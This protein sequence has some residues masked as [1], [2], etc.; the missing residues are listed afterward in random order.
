MGSYD[1]MLAAIYQQVG[2][3]DEAIALLRKMMKSRRVDQSTIQRRIAFSLFKMHHYDEAEEALKKLLERNPHDRTA[4]RWLKGLEDA[5]RVGSY[6][7]AEEIINLGGLAEEGIELS[8]LAQ[9]AINNCTFEGVEPKKLQSGKITIKEAEHLEDLAKQLGTKR[10][11]DR[12]AFFLS[13]AAIMQ[14]YSEDP[15]S[16]RIYGFLRRYFNSMADASWSDKKPADVVRSYYIESLALAVGFDLDE[17]WRS[18]LRYLATFAPGLLEDVQ[19][20][21]P[22]TRHITMAD[23]SRALRETLLIVGSEV[24]STILLNGLLAVGSQSSFVKESVSKAITSGDSI[25]SL[26]GRLLGTSKQV[27]PP[28]LRKEWQDQCRD[29]AR[30][31]QKLLAVCRTLV[32]YE[33]TA[34][35]MEDLGEQLG[36]MIS[37]DISELD[38]S[39]IGELQDI[40]ECSYDYCRGSD[41]EEKEQQYW[42]VTTR[43]ERLLDSVQGNPTQFSYEG[44]LP[45]SEQVRAVIEEEYAQLVRTSGA[46][47]TLRLLVDEYVPGPGGEL[48]LQIEVSNKKGCSPASSVRV[49]VG[50]K[51]SEYFVTE[52]WE[53]E[54]TPTLRG[55]ASVVAQISIRP[56]RIALEERAFPISAVAVFKNRLGDEKHTH[57]QTS[58]TVRLYRDEEFRG[59]S[60]NPYT[61]YAEGGPVEDVSMFV[62]RD[63]LLDRLE[64]SLISAVSCKSIILFGQKRAGKSSLLS[65]LKRKLS[66]QN[67]VV[68][69]TL[70]V[71]DVAPQV[72]MQFLLYRMLGSLSEVLEEMHYDGHQVPK[73]KA[74]RPD[75][76]AD[77]P[78]LGFHDAMSAFTREMKRSRL[79]LKIV[80]MIDEFTDVFKQI[81]KG[82]IPREFMKAWKSIVERQY[83]SSVLVGQDIMPEFKA[84]FPNEFGVTEDVRVTYLKESSAREL[85]ERPIGADR[86]AGTAVGRIVELTAGSPYYTMMFCARL[87]DYINDTRSAIVTEADVL[88]V[89][90]QMLSG[91]G[92]L[93]QDKFDNL[94]RAGDGFEDSGVNPDESLKVCTE[95]VRKS[96]KG[97]C[98]FDLI[99]GFEEDDLVE[100]LKD[101]E[102]RDVVER[103]D[104]AFRLR[105]GL[106]R[107][108][109]LV[110]Q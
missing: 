2:M 98:L 21:L 27:E 24:E 82:A 86:F 45:I 57:E 5:R 56:R 53:K 3:H 55:G 50:P 104:Q 70:S 78:V 38:R 91:D 10:P 11:R 69:V 51:T 19:K 28:A 90:G 20:T 76:L 48:R 87:V 64:S 106:F 31:R 95:I 43:A 13:A 58:W 65:H 63:D 108:W 49:K 62:G 103:R 80:F 6:V 101:L 105:V 34:A 54:F 25:L 8:S 79:K 37:V 7:E 99:E 12:A 17:V 107:D 110:N 102:R 74:P 36:A 44:L 16:T 60:E 96:R 42:N 109:L 9:F 14:R 47:L 39:R 81:R 66:L 4:E 92:R 73:F 77:H 41:F 75:A 100:L 1:N 88:A 93:S 97:W 89:E 72:S 32:N 15:S 18:L 85:I 29:F 83:F 35:S 84:Q 94:I 68:P 59:I 40:V 23:Y 46:D 67:G 61:P 26:F 33:A 71:Q 52:E 30:R 22:R